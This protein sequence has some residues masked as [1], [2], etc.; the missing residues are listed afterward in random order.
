[1]K[2]SVKAIEKYTEVIHSDEELNDVTENDSLN[3][4]NS[5]KEKIREYLGDLFSWDPQNYQIALPNSE[6]RNRATEMSGHK[7]V[8]AD[9][10]N[11][12]GNSNDNYGSGGDTE[13]IDIESQRLNQFQAQT[14]L[15]EDQLKSIRETGSFVAGPENNKWCL[16]VLA[17]KGKVNIKNTFF[18]RLSQFLKVWIIIIKNLL[19]SFDLFS[20]PS[21]FKH[22]FLGMNDVL[23]ML[24]G[25]PRRSPANTYYNSLYLKFRRD[26]VFDGLSSDD[27]FVHG[28]LQ[29]DYFYSLFQKLSPNVNVKIDNRFMSNIEL[30]D[31]VKKIALSV[32][33]EWEKIEAN[34]QRDELNKLKNQGLLESKTRDEIKTYIFTESIKKQKEILNEGL[35]HNFS[36]EDLVLV[37]ANAK[38]NE[39]YLELKKKY[40]DLYRN[41]I[42]SIEKNLNEYSIKS[43]ITEWYETERAKKIAQYELDNG[44][45]LE[46]ELV[47]QLKEESIKMPELNTYLCIAESHLAFLRDKWPGILKKLRTE[48]VPSITF[49]CYQNIWNPNKW[50]KRAMKINE[51]TQH[52]T[53]KWVIE[54]KHKVYNCNSYYPFWRLWIFVTRMFVYVSNILFYLIPVLLINS[55][56]GLKAL[57][58]IK[59][60]TRSYKINE[61]TGEIEPNKKELGDTFCSRILNLWRTVKS[62]RDEF[63]LKP[64]TGIIS[65][66]IGR[67]FNRVWNYVIRGMCGTILILLFFPLV[68]ILC[69]C[70]AIILS[71]LSP[72]CVFLV[73]VL[74]WLFEILI[75]DFYH[76]KSSQGLFY[77]SV[78]PLFLVI[79]ADI[80]F[81]AVTV[82]FCFVFS[83]ALGLASFFIVFYSLIEWT[84]STVW[85]A[86]FF[87]C[88]L[89]KYGRVPVSDNFL[90]KRVRGGDIIKDHFFKI[91]PASALILVQIYLENLELTK[92]EESELQK[93]NEPCELAKAKYTDLFG[94]LLGSN[95]KHNLVIPDEITTSSKIIAA[96]LKDLVEERRK[97]LNKYGMSDKSLV[98]MSSKDLEQTLELSTHLI[99]NFYQ[100]KL[101]Q[102]MISN[103]F[104]NAQ[105]VLFDD[106]V[107]CAEKI[108]KKVLSDEIMTPIEESAKIFE[109]GVDH[110]EME[111]F[112]KGLIKNKPREDLDPMSILAPIIFNKNVQGKLF[113]LVDYSSIYF[114]SGNDTG[115]GYYCGTN[116][117]ITSSQYLATLASPI[118]IEYYVE[119]TF[120]ERKYKYEET[121]KKEIKE[122]KDEKET[123]AVHKVLEALRRR[124]LE[125]LKEENSSNLIHSSSSKHF[126]S[127]N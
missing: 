42:E 114:S 75:S 39:I 18:L 99:K 17:Q 118:S 15:S 122:K 76:R 70:A 54:S 103:V 68:S 55:P 31:T 98:R 102:Y 12:R 81:G 21:G 101:S 33:L 45:A 88:V 77:L 37:R 83:I 40:A 41:N 52:E 25:L 108:L 14:H 126:E 116:T 50:S 10:E 44:Y 13:I 95:T 22:V 104:F 38:A 19:F 53:K 91:S 4:L 30:R 51:D 36:P 121:H 59:P 35:E 61:N 124:S 85:D 27:I 123:K 96:K 3:S 1:M 113:D 49:T 78:F 80:L 111:E 46:T 2:K 26:Y 82:V 64:D 9:N 67:F 106:W 109:L 74:I 107:S 60:F 72:F 86:F 93:I 5:V 7:I 20:V 62:A 16:S 29:G 94:E 79:T 100:K 65:K 23:N 47:A 119:K 97:E 127:S 110:V 112:I 66:D 57:F 32:K 120:R 48:K 105:G 58:Y 115:S 89:K 117:K 84:A 28:Q 87:N 90:A 24:I 11:L 43:K 8:L 63:E 34:F 6:L 56:I 71:L 92:F 125:A 73:C 69:I